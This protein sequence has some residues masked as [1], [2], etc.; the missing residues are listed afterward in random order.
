MVHNLRGPTASQIKSG[1]GAMAP[2]A[3]LV[4]HLFHVLS[5]TMVHEAKLRHR[6][7]CYVER[8]AREMPAC[9]ETR[10]L[11]SHFPRGASLL[12]AS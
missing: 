11:T 8:H 4:P 12:A 9:R 5:N 10:Q 2:L 7:E 3:P 6:G 1:G